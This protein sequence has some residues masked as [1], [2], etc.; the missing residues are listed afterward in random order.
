MFGQAT[1]TAADWERM[2]MGY[3]PLGVFT[4]VILYFVIVYGRRAAE[5]HISLVT[6]LRKATIRQTK[7]AVKQA[8]ADQRTT[9]ALETLSRTLASHE[10]LYRTLAD[11]QKQIVATQTDIQR[12]VSEQRR[13]HQKFMEGAAGGPAVLVDARGS[14]IKQE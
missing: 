5:G 11:T 1:T 10:N 8:D 14:E 6:T 3:G 2:L 12:E 7:A 13:L 9:A 4:L